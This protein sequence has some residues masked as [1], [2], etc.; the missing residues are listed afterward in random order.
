M[1]SSK[2]ETYEFGGNERDYPEWSANIHALVEMNPKLDKVFKAD[3]TINT[4]LGASGDAA[5]MAQ[6]V[7]FYNFLH[8][9]T[10]GAAN[11]TIKEH[12]R[13]GVA[14]WSL[15][16]QEYA[17]NTP[18]HLAYIRR[19]LMQLKLGAN[20]D[21]FISKIE[22]IR[23]QASATGNPNA[24]S[25]EVV[26]EYCISQLPDSF[27]YLA[28]P[29]VGTDKWKELRT[30]IR[31]HMKMHAS[32][33][34][35][36]GT[37]SSPT[38]DSLQP[39]FVLATPKAA[40]PRFC[41]LC[42][43]RNHS[44]DDCKYIDMASQYV[45]DHK[46]TIA[47][48]QR[49]SNASENP[50]KASGSSKA[51]FNPAAHAAFFVNGRGTNTKAAGDG[52]VLLSGA[53]DVLTTKAFSAAVP[54]N[55][56]GSDSHM[57]SHTFIVD[58]GASQHV[59][60]EAKLFTGTLQ[61][62]KERV[63]TASGDYIEATAKGTAAVTV[64]SENGTMI[65]ITLLDAL[66]I[67]G[68]TNLLSAVKLVRAGH[69]IKFS[70][71]GSHISLLLGDR[72]AGYSGMRHHTIH[73][74]NHPDYG[75]PTLS[76]NRLSTKFAAAAVI[77]GP[78]TTISASVAHQ[79]LG[80]LNYADMLKMKK[81]GLINFKGTLEPCDVCL[82]T[83]SKHAPVRKHTVSKRDD[84]KTP[85]TERLT[86]GNRTFCDINGPLPVPSL[87][88][89]RWVIEFIDE[90]SNY[91]QVFLMKTKD[92]AT[93]KLQL[94]LDFMR[95]CNH[96]IGP[97]CK[98]KS[99][100]DSVFRDKKFQHVLRTYGITFQASPPHTQAMNG[101]A[102]SDKRPTACVNH[103]RDCQRPHGLLRLVIEVKC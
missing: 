11:V 3:G 103:C 91:V 27:N 49:S 100:N 76:V 78:S 73:L 24:L 47:A 57:A 68:V 93:S 52:P 25:D 28:L 62:C 65:T 71:E 31:Q 41:K 1:E 10:K 60:G 48:R 46:R 80:H 72:R 81:Q 14:A 9:S 102:E 74:S 35:A 54:V 98:F 6:N 33:Q 15:L 101:V 44:T 5:E 50:R 58:T 26:V 8:I 87:Q 51:S 43:K 61:P 55:T 2:I 42:K 63:M 97:G 70:E 13:D 89:H 36:S 96:T 39:A 84:D 90:A 53:S 45:K 64:Y 56:S 69:N 16:Q 34:E 75:L 99:D 83:K 23:A 29:L 22:Q 59:I 66:F 30:A 19:Q 18:A 4:A 79:R 77:P 94:Y 67:P 82:A 20:M 95:S 85:D 92:E 40:T 17:P 32:R 21:K 86:I 12:P 88:G 37:T 38:A 7:R